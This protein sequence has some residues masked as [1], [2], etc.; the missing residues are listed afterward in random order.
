VSFF[1]KNADIKNDDGSLAVDAVVHVSIVNGGLE[2]YINIEPPRYGGAAPTLEVLEESLSSCGVTHNIDVEKLKELAK[3]PVYNR[4]ILVARG[5]PPVDGDDG[6]V[7]F[8]IRTEKDL[9]PK[10]REDGTVDF[11]DLDLVENVSRGQVLCTITPPTEGTPGISVRGEVLPQKKGRPAPSFVG[12]NTELNEDGTTII[13]KIDGQVDFDGRKINV[14]ETFTVSGDVDTSTGNVKVAGNLVVRGMVLPG[15]EIEA[16]GNIDVMGVV[17]GSTIRAG[18][19]ITLKSGI[20]GS[21]I[22][23]NGDLKSRFIEN[24][25][26]FVKGDITAEYILNSN[27]KCGKNIKV[28]GSIAKII[29][30][31][32]MAGQDIVART[33]GSVANVKTSLELGTDP[34]S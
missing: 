19:N 27:I 16:G 24:C 9:K 14:S 29:G 2:A 33:I 34:R 13:S 20:T 18:G 12:K 31:S 30:G 26:V 10:E 7:T 17:E 23:C 22:Y 11:L 32:C 4:D 25:T 28:I 8:H 3:E 15:F 21:K 5:V 6:T 1:K